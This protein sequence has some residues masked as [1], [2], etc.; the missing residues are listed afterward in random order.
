MTDATPITRGLVERFGDYFARPVAEN[1]AKSLGNGAEIE[2]RIGA[3][4]IFTFTRQA[5]RNAV[6]AG[7][8]GDPQVV[9]AL[10]ATAAEEILAD[11]SED[12]GQIGVQIAKLIVSPDANRRVSVKLKTGF[13]TLWNKGYFGVI[14]AGGGPFAAFLASKG[15]NGL[16]AIKDTLKNLRS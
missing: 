9:F 7:A 1:A 15:L 6:R 14:A 3:A 10:S 13:L 12:I 11:S 2:F 16:G 8:A 4:E 5:G